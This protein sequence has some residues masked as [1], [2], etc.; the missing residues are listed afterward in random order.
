[1]EKFFCHIKHDKE[2]QIKDR[3]FKK[4]QSKENYD[5]II[6]YFIC[7]TKK[8]P[9][10]YILML[11]DDNCVPMYSSNF[12]HNDYKHYKSGKITFPTKECYKHLIESHSTGSSKGK[13][14]YGNIH[15]KHLGSETGLLDVAI[16]EPELLDVAIA[17]PDLI[18]FL[19][20]IDPGVLSLD[21]L[22]ALGLTEADLG[23]LKY[24]VVN[25]KDEKAVEAFNKIPVKSRRFVSSLSKSE[26]E[27]LKTA[28]LSQYKSLDKFNDELN[29]KF[30]TP[31]KNAN[32][33]KGVNF[34]GG[35]LTPEEE[36]QLGKAI[37][38]IIIGGGVIASILAAIGSI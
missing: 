35:G 20:I 22:N 7:K 16:A 13:Y 12:K 10:R 1:M 24:I 17:E 38:G 8:M 26:K 34:K 19:A 5:N 6:K 29:N 37:K 4:D 32:P 21:D 3:L 25:E 28:D 9:K 30:L 18:P 33:T 27:F 2:F 36:K 14:W 15:F 11:A 31:I 23:K